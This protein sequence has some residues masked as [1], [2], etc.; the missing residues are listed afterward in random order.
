MKTRVFTRLTVLTMAALLTSGALAQT[1]PAPSPVIC[2]PSPT[3]V[4]VQ[5]E[6]VN[7]P[8]ADWDKIAAQ[9]NRVAAIRQ[10]HYPTLS[11]PT[12]T[13]TDGV[14][15][16]MSEQTQVPFGPPEKRGFVTIGS[17]TKVKPS[18]NKDGSIRLQF[19]LHDT[20]L[21]GP[22]AAPNDPPP[23]ASASLSLTR[24]V[25]SNVTYIMGS[26]SVSGGKTLQVILLTATIKTTK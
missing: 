8:Q 16:N 22:A 6:I 7:V 14:E 12:V 21:A 13:T 11:S 2:K 15:A 25:V 18:V 19:S 5:W 1:K 23:T 9:G 26:L 17:Q 24:T 3:Q 10:G 4:S 20:E